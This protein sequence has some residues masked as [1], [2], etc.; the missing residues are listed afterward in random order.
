MGRSNRLMRWLIALR[1]P[2]LVRRTFWRVPAKVVA[3]TFPRHEHYQALMGR[4]G[5][6]FRIQDPAPIRGEG[7]GRFPLSSFHFAV[8]LLGDR[9]ACWDGF[10]SRRSI[11]PIGRGDVVFRLLSS[12]QGE[13]G[14]IPGGVDH[15]FSHVGIVPDDSAG[16]RVFLENSRFPSSCIPALLRLASPTSALKTSILRATQISSLNNSL[17]LGVGGQRLYL[18]VSC[19]GPLVPRTPA[20]HANKMASLTNMSGHQS[21]AGNLTRQQVAQPVGNLPHHA[22][23]NRTRGLVSGISHSQS[24]AEYA[25]IK[26][27]SV[28]SHPETLLP[29]PSAAPPAKSPTAISL[30]LVDQSTLLAPPRVCVDII[31]FGRSPPCTGGGDSRKIADIRTA[32]P[33]RYSPQ[34]LLP[35]WFPALASDASLDS[36]EA[37]RPVSGS[38]TRRL[39]PTPIFS[40]YP[41]TKFL[42]L[43]EILR[44]KECWIS[45]FISK[46]E[47]TSRE[48]GAG[49]NQSGVQAH[50]SREGSG[51][52]GPLPPESPV[53]SL[54][55]KKKGSELPVSISRANTCWF[56]HD[57]KKMAR[58]CEKK[59]KIINLI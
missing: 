29:G 23:A 56:L 25:Q 4:D 17:Y 30:A 9:Y 22:V 39:S 34:R 1:C 14:S 2:G 31:Q 24:A 21:T 13:P 59:G 12:H 52:I 32:S 19:N 43:E 40:N 54:K 16:L 33:V 47:N 44:E 28:V 26:G 18:N 41:I 55:I 42:Y 48:E 3:S 6:S 15:G 27:I 46:D 53:D 57:Q 50:H 7:C 58:T 38:K 5:K 37:S 20:A 45:F 51:A 36:V 10:Y 35:R 8:H 11:R 49:F